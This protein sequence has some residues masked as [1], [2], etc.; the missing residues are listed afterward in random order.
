[1]DKIKLAIVGAGTMAVEHARAFKA[2]NGAELVAIHSRT[3]SRAQSVADEF[4]IRHVVDS[5]AEMAALGAQLVIVAVPELATRGVVE[6]CLKHEWTMLL[7][8][9][10]GYN[11]DEAEAIARMFAGSVNP[12][13]VALN[14]R[15]YSS[16]QRI[17]NALDSAAHERRFIHVQDQQSYAEARAHRHP[18]P[19]VEHFMYAN[20]IHNI[21]LIRAFGRG[22]IENINPLMPWK[23]GD[24]EV[25]LAH[26]AFD[27][28]DAAIY[29]GLWKGPGPWACSISTPSQRWQMMPLE[30]ATLQKAGER[31]RE[32]F[33]RDQVDIDFKPG[34][35]R[36]AEAVLVAMRGDRDA[37]VV[38]FAESLATMRLIH[39]IF[40]V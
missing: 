8:K 21:D 12:A 23:G 9:P 31:K 27:S 14:R 26:I 2:L 40:G 39:G 28:G 4:G 5:I 22:S 18:E 16:F 35:L 25:V 17:G 36:Q 13:F 19:V 34:L 33:P 37:Q 3:R 6:T 32:T 30:E 7:E 11:L 15:F 29:E 38:T 24:T 10:V 1:M 20:S